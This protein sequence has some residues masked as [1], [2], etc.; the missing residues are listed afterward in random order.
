[1][2]KLPSRLGAKK[3]SHP[4]SAPGRPRPVDVRVVGFFRSFLTATVIAPERGWRPMGNFVDKVRFI[5]SV[6]DMP[7]NPGVE[8]IELTPENNTAFRVVPEPVG[9]LDSNEGSR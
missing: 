3:L 2:T 1:M 9:Y 7:L 6:A 5:W 8:P 4:A